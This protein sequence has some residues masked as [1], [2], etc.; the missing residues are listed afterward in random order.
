MKKEAGTARPR[1]RTLS[2]HVLGKG[3]CC[4]GVQLAPAAL[5][6]SVSLLFSWWLC[7][8][9]LL[10]PRPICWSVSLLISATPPTCTH[11]YTRPVPTTPFPVSWCWPFHLLP[12]GFEMSLQEVLV[13]RGGSSRALWLWQ[14][15]FNWEEARRIWKNWNIHETPFIRHNLNSAWKNPYMYK[16]KSTS[17]L[18]WALLCSPPVQ[19]GS[20]KIPSF[21][22][23]KSVKVD[24]GSVAGWTEKEYRWVSLLHPHMGVRA[25][26]HAH[27]HTHAADPL[28][29]WLCFRWHQNP[30]F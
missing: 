2:R 21:H 10:V 15:S 19:A 7:F 13:G 16:E 11:T 4:Q 14:T 26:T 6:S 29:W 25:R 9:C 3:C 28:C 5:D 1:E 18:L 23:S 22:F 8:P 17:L 12:R 20:C 30:S 27:T 24:L